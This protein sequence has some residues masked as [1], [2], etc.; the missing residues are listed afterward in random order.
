MIVC[1]CRAL[2]DREILAAI[3]AGAGDTQQIAQTC[4]AGREC[5]GCR[6][7]LRRMLERAKGGSKP[8]TAGEGQGTLRVQAP[9]LATG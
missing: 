9:V 7:V 4:G 5:G 6:P 2:S 1:H 3:Q 8:Q